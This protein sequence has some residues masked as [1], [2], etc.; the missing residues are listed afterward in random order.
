MDFNYSFDF[1]HEVM[2]IEL[3][4]DYGDVYHHGISMV[5]AKNMADN[6]YMMIGKLDKEKIHDEQ[7]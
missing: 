4:N 6:I 2:D 5:D 1:R 3:L 7:K